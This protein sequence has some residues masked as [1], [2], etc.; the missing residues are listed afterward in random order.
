MKQN[1]TKKQILIFLLVAFC[2]GWI[3]QTIASYFANLGTVSGKAVFS[4]IVIVNMFMP[5][6]G[7]LIA[8]IS[9]KGMGWKPQLKKNLKWIAYSLWMQALLAA[10]G[11]ELSWPHLR[12]AA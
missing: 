4:A 1:I 11:A 9:L 5:F 12:S 10:V 8:R 6:S 2:G 3:L 7:V